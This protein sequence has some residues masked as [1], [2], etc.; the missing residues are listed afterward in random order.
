MTKDLEIDSKQLVDAIV[1]SMEDKKGLEIAYIDFSNVP[2]TIARYFVICHGTSNTQVAT[3][4]D[5][6]IDGV[7]E[8]LGSKPWNKEGYENAEWI[9]LDYADVVVHI[10]QENSRDFYNL[11]D[12]WADMEIT[13]IESKQ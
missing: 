6:V 3:L 8:T 4:A 13:Q 1:S 5:G 9:L 7:R 10:F 12:L 11:E 2:N